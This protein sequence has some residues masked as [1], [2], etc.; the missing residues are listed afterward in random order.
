LDRTSGPD[1]IIRWCDHEGQFRVEFSLA[2]CPSERP[3][4][5]LLAR[6]G[7]LR[8][9]RLTEPIAVVQVWSPE[10]RFMPSSQSVAGPSARVG[11]G[12]L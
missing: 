5:A 10:P 6:S 7:L 12:A 8:E 11:I 2:R 1:S 3:E 4:S 9:G